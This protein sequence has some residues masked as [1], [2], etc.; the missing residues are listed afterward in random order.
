MYTYTST[1]GRESQEYMDD[2]TNHEPRNLESLDARHEIF[3]GER[4]PHRGS[5]E[6]RRALR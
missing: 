3:Y 6:R 4:I 2:S 1:T 5:A